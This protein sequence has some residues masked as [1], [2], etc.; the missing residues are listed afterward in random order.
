[1][2]VLWLL[3]ALGARRMRFGSRIGIVRESRS[4]EAHGV[5]VWN[6]KTRVGLLLGA[7][8][9]GLFFWWLIFL[10]GFG[11]VVLAT[12]QEGGTYTV[13]GNGFADFVKEG[14]A[15]FRVETLPSKGTPE[16]LKLLEE[17]VAD[18]AIVQSGQATSDEVRVVA[19]LYSEVLHILV[20]RESSFDS[21]S[22]LAGKRLC[23]G[24]EGSGSR[25]V[26]LPLLAHFGV[27]ADE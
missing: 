26:S 11:T 5:I 13:L 24:E 21:L 7:G 9:L 17:G 23:L 4:R 10:R 19:K 22:E 15:R 6:W 1:M 16:N 27:D 14:D 8:L 2:W 20:A 25:V 3:W 18:F 12:G